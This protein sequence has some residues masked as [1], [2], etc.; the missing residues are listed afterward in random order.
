MASKALVQ[1]FDKHVQSTDRVAF[2]K[3]GEEIYPRR[4]FSLVKKDKN[5]TQLKN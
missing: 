2:I 5:L 3:Y 4:I 1:I